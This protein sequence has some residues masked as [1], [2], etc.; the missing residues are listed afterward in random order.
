VRQARSLPGHW[1][2]TTDPG[3]NGAEAALKPA[4]VICWVLPRQLVPGRWHHRT[5]LVPRH[6]GHRPEV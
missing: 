5:G 6:S 2:K 1:R 4:A 3:W